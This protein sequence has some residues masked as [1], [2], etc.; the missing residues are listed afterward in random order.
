MQT[1]QTVWHSRSGR[2]QR[3]FERCN[4]WVHAQLRSG[5]RTQT[6][7]VRDVSPGGMKIEYAYGLRPGD[8]VTIELNSSRVFEATVAW[9]VATY[10]GV[11]FSSPLAEDDPALVARKVH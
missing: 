2:K 8:S 3:T 6:I 5:E 10:C 9:S 11:E 7:V 4:A 1:T